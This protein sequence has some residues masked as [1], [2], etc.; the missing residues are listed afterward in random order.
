MPDS[1]RSA[2]YLVTR[3]GGEKF[4]VGT[5]LRKSTVEGAPPAFR[6]R[7]RTTAF[8]ANNTRVVP[9]AHRKKASEKKTKPSHTHTHTPQTRFRLRL[10]PRASF[11]STLSWHS[12]ASG[13]SVGGPRHR[14]DFFSGARLFPVTG[15]WNRFWPSHLLGELRGSTAAGAGECVTFR[16]MLL[17]GR[18]PACN[19]ATHREEPA[20]YCQG[21]DAR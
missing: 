14:C 21:T 3:Q 19:I 11:R 12:S 1:A 8:K 6:V 2:A 17:Q 5:S 13:P 15:R 16:V 4:Q 9:M 10:R 18:R 20:G 7:V